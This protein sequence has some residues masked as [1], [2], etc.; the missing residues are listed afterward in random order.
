ML[1]DLTR[2]DLTINMEGPYYLDIIIWS[3]DVESAKGSRHMID[4]REPNS[5]TKINEFVKLLTCYREIEN[6]NDI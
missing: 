2:F 1:M 4:L 3:D 6:E 5:L